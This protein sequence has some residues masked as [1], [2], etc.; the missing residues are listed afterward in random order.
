MAVSQPGSA[1]G[2]ALDAPRRP[3]P[4]L[5][6]QSDSDRLLDAVRKGLAPGDP[7]ARLLSGWVA[8]PARAVVCI[9]R[10]RPPG[11]TLP[12]AAIASSVA[13]TPTG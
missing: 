5:P 3:E 8:P 7:V 2:R 6:Q 12:A 11:V 13:G 10:G 4:V 1:A 9:T